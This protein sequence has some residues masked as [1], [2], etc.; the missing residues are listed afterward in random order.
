MDGTHS[1]VISADGTR[2][3]LLTGGA[4]PSLLMVH[5]GMC[6][7]GRWAPLWPLMI[8]HF[9]VTVMDRRGR[10]SS[11]D[12]QS[13]YSLGAEYDDVTAVA[14]HLAAHQ[15]EPVDVFG[16]SYGAVCALGAAAQGAP[17]R[18]L[19]LYEPPGPQT[20]PAPWLDRIRP[21][22]AQGQFGRVMVSFLT[23]IIGLTRDQVEG[24]RASPGGPDPLPIVEKTLL[25]EAEALTTLDLIGLA[26]GLIQ[27][28]HLLLG[29]NSPPWAA[30]VTHT[31][32]DA[33]PDV[34]VGVLPDQDHEAID[35]APD[36]VAVHLHRFLL[37]H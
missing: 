17:L 18:R 25:R 32:V 24:L 9:R 22:I 16:H 26:A 2:I 27:P 5:G 30:A 8:E 15:R 28:V 31:L 23:E 35:T 36:L 6:S 12:T 3:G 1:S 10:A 7:S 21:M 29:S 14:E 4:G 37:D 33:L 13:S 19:V 11:P 20:V 34:T